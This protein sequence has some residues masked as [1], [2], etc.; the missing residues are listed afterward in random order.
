MEPS[1]V[2]GEL[3]LTESESTVYLTLLRKGP[4]TASAVAK[5]A[6]IHRRLAYD[7]MESLTEKGL[8]SYVDKE[9]RR[10]Y[11]P[12]HPERLKELVEEQRQE[13]N[14]L[15][16]QIDDVLP[17]L[18]TQFNAEQEEREVKVLQGKEG[19]KHLFE[20]ELREEE[21]IYLIGSPEESEDIL[22]Y[23]LPSWTERRVEKG[24]KIKGVFEHAMRGM[25]G[26]HGKLEDRYLAEDHDSNVSIAVYGDK[27]G[28]I[29]WIDNPLVIMINDTEAAASFMS[30]FDLIWDAANE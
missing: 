4:D 2:L 23:F 8:V 13:L 24:I 21:T 7:T 29:F 17:D 16:Q 12:T 28:I 5:Q 11:K 26:E 10:V 30:Y 19:V 27:V 1:E 14:E 18:L 3:D 25:V 15:E 6:G 9:N 20:D 22:K